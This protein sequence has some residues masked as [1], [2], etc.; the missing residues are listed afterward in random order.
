[1]VKIALEDQLHFQWSSDPWDFEGL[2][3]TVGTAQGHTP[4]TASPITLL[5]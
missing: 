4:L 2:K 1:M 5:S 3:E